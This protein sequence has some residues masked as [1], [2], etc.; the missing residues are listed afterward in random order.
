MQGETFI[1]GVLANGLYMET[2]AGDFTVTVDYSD[3]VEETPAVT[4]DYTQIGEDAEY[5]GT[6]SFIEI[7]SASD[8]SAIETIESIKIELTDVV[9]G[10]DVSEGDEWWFTPGQRFVWP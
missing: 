7:A 6:G 8:L 5:E 1:A 9:A 10:E 4:Y 3:E 2:S